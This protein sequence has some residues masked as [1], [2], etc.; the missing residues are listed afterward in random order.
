MM[1][2]RASPLI[3]GKSW[4]QSIKGGASINSSA[5]SS[6]VPGQVALNRTICR[7][8]TVLQ[9]PLQRPTFCIKFAAMATRASGLKILVSVVRFRP[10]ALEV[11]ES[12]RPAFTGFFRSSIW[13][14]EDIGLR[15]VELV[16]QLAAPGELSLAKTR[17][18]G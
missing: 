2:N 9:S 12:T 18:N 10:W 7:V 8:T 16:L 6:A 11:P 17:S 5:L 4:H 13:A 3:R 14:V 1:K 15:L